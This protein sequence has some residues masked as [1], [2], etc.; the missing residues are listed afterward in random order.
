LP[1]D[2]RF[3]GSNPAKEDGILRVIKMCSTISFVEEVKLLALYC[4]ILWHVKEP[5]DL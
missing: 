1:S 3:T 4:K 5:Y 2:P